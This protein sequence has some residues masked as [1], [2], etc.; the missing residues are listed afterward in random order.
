MATLNRCDFNVVRPATRPRSIAFRV[1]DLR[2]G[3]ATSPLK[4]AL[5]TVH[6]SSSGTS[7]KRLPQGQRSRSP[8]CLPG[9][10][11]AMLVRRI[12]R[13]WSNRLHSRT[14]LRR[15]RR[16][17][18]QATMRCLDLLNC[19][20]RV[21]GPPK[22]PLASPRQLARPVSARYYIRW[23]PSRGRGRGEIHCWKRYPPRSAIGHSRNIQP[24]CGRGADM[25]GCKPRSCWACFVHR[26]IPERGQPRRRQAAA[27]ASSVGS[28]TNSLENGGAARRVGVGKHAQGYNRAGPPGCDLKIAARPHARVKAGAPSPINT[29]EISPMNGNE[30]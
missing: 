8:I 20:R 21:I 14:S 19:R 16:V 29:D 23:E 5:M 9:S 22:L 7:L 12:V 3:E 2:P 18:T 4:S 26:G 27:L 1:R 30:A 24:P 10:C 17:L 11:A 25:S 6:N 13:G 15:S 28:R